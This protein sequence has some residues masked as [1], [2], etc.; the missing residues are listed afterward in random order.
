MLVYIY[1]IRK[2]GFKIIYSQ[3]EIKEETTDILYYSAYAKFIGRRGR[4]RTLW[5]EGVDKEFIEQ[6]MFRHNIRDQLD[7]LDS[8]NFFQKKW[9]EKAEFYSKIV[10]N[11]ESF[12]YHG[13][14]E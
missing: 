2:R 6:A 3:I 1:T 8:V 14:G 10:N 7:Y 11:A 12:F 4:P 9:I 13:Y 5:H